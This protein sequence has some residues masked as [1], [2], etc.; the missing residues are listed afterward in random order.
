MTTFQ[1]LANAS[2]LCTV[3]ALLSTFFGATLISASH[4]DAPVPLLALL[5]GITALGVYC[6][7][8]LPIAFLWDTE[9]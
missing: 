4:Q 7:V 6:T 5:A 2:I 8:M 9:G 1:R 3:F